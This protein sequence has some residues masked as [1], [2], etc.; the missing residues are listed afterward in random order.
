MGKFT[1]YKLPLKSLGTGKHQFE[2]HLDT[3]FFA[4]L[5]M[6][7]IREADIRVALSVVY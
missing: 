4:N 1:A 3:Q 2:Y 7:D 6:T 5:E